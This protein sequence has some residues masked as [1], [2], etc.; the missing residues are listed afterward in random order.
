MSSSLNAVIQIPLRIKSLIAEVN[1]YNAYYELY[2]KFI[3]NLETQYKE[4]VDYIFNLNDKDLYIQLN[5]ELKDINDNTITQYITGINS[6]LNKCKKESNIKKKIELQIQLH[7]AIISIKKK[8]I[9]SYKDKLTLLNEE[10][11]EEKFVAP[12]LKKDYVLQEW[13][14][15]NFIPYKPPVQ[16]PVQPPSQTVQPAITSTKAAKN[17][18]QNIDKNQIK[19]YKLIKN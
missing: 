3:K 4:D 8:E 11:L 15:E 17:I 14:P 5:K 13:V 7:E 18:F 1:K 6:L 12:P 16:P 9:L 19:K 10:K 2:T